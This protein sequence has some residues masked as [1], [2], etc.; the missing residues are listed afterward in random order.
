MTNRA[1][2]ADDIDLQEVDCFA[3]FERLGVESDT[4]TGL[5][6]QPDMPRA[7]AREHPE[8]H[9][10][11]Q[12]GRRYYNR[13]VPH[14]RLYGVAENRLDPG[15]EFVAPPLT[16]EMAREIIETLRRP[17]ASEES[18]R[19]A[20]IGERLFAN[21]LSG[22]PTLEGVVGDEHRR[23]VRLRQARVPKPAAQGGGRKI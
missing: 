13:D 2:S 1:L 19:F 18:L 21:I 9:V 4:V 8:I 23:N 15:V 16:P 20:D 7:L 6:L 14:A 5:F 10:I 22:R 11:S 17:G 12:I 3:L